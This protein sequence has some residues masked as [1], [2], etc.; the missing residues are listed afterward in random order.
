M[1]GRASYLALRD[2]EPTMQSAMQ[3]IL[4]AD[5]NKTNCGTYVEQ[6]LGVK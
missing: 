2:V 6:Q 1:A 3:R 4:R 5:G